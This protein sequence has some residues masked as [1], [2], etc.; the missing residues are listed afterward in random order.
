MQQLDLDA[1]ADE[2]KRQGFGDKSI[3]LYDVRNELN[4]R[5]KDLRV[6]YQQPSQEE[7]FN[8]VTKETP[9]TLYIG[10]LVTASVTGFAYRKPQREQLDR[11]NP[12]R[13]EETGWWQCPFCFKVSYNSKLYVVR[14]IE[15]Y[16]FL[17]V[18]E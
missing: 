6:P 5:Y 12:V 3:T 10:K 14:S 18:S 8:M 15:F 17:S 13:N 4:D 1:F 7:I 16:E 2:L 9:E 11:A